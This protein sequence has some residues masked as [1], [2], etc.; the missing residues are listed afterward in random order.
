MMARGSN[1]RRRTTIGLLADALHDDYQN[2]VVCGI[3]EAAR[4]HGVNLVVFAGGILRSPEW[5][6]AQRNA[7][8]ELAGPHSVDGL[9]VMAGTLGNHVG[10]RELGRFCERYRPLPMCSMAV[11]L[12]GMPCVLVDNKSGMRA[13]VEHLIEHHACRRIAFIRGPRNNEE[14]EG[15]YRV[16]CEVL[17]ERGLELDR[18]LIL[19]GDFQ[20]SAGASAV[21]ALI[22]ER[23]VMPDALV[24]ASDFMALGAIEALE[25]HG[26]RVPGDVLVVGFDDVGES[27][28]SAPA[29]TTVHQ[30]LG[31][32]GRRAAE[33]LLAL[34]DGRSVEEDQVLHTE[35]VI[36]RSCG[37]EAGAEARAAAEDPVAAAWEVAR[38]QAQL[39]Y[40]AEHWAR[41]LSESGE[42]LI[43]SF[44]AGSLDRALVERLP[45][46]GVPSACVSLYEGKSEHARVAVAW[47]AERGLDTA[48]RGRAF[49]A[50]ELVPRDLLP[51]R[52]RTTLLV[53]PLFFED[54]PLGFAVL[55]M[56][57]RE[58]VIYEALRDQ[59]SA[60][61]HG[62]RLVQR[63]LHKDR[64]RER[65]LRYVLE[66]T[67]HLHRMQPLEDLL[68]GILERVSGFAPERDGT[69]AGLV[70]VLEDDLEL[71][72]RAATGRFAGTRSLEACLPPERIES[73][74]EAL[75]RGETRVDET[76]TI[77]PLR[78]GDLTQGVMYFDGAVVS[79]EERELFE[80]FSNQATAAIRGVQLYE[81]AALD[82][83]T[84]AHARRFFD[85]WMRREVRAA[86]RS[87]QPLTLLM[88]DMD[89]L[90]AINDGAG[91]L[92]GD[93]ALAA[94]GRVLRLAMRDSDLV[95]RYGGD[96]FAVVLPRTPAEGAA[97]VAERVLES[98]AADDA[99]RGADAVAVRLR[100]SL[101]LATLEP[102]ADDVDPGKPVAAGYFAAV[103]HALVAEA[104]AALYRAKRAGGSRIAAG[105][106][107]GWPA[108]D[109]TAS[110]GERLGA[111]R[112]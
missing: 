31:E 73:V 98:L 37:C 23:R 53:E 44:E 91:H 59:L 61:L 82:P 12:E 33:A 39:R 72:V 80:I 19:P 17:A 49:P 14:A 105:D 70:A 94:V 65:L 58:G 112:V 68:H 101:G 15:R 55:E 25:A 75:R 71:V 27:R 46:L 89:G 57:P 76:A 103:V 3:E 104:D 81:M 96:E 79:E 102:R 11:R 66:V 50:Q 36:R 34:L 106:S 93:R 26:L 32:Q 21:H 43:T 51:A 10:P 78:V 90:K 111:G 56:G 67:P 109:A 60:A 38:E 4:V 62:A 88:L 30:P 13:V 18:G 74:L 77:V 107:V 64:A 85:Q 42:A 63:V 1:H 41:S 28:F 92:A 52:R 47:D 2:A 84:G 8:H 100:A 16:Y 9:I 97:R 7:V 83:L 6:G 99:G 54:E 48:A 95:G 108:L 110:P 22:E 35:L 86:F 24:A 29:L 69:A 20:R 5:R 40:R 87:A 45:R